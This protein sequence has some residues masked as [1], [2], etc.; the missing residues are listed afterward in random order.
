MLGTMYEYQENCDMWQPPDPRGAGNRN[1]YCIS[2]LC[3]FVTLYWLSHYQRDSVKLV[4]TW[5]TGHHIYLCRN[6]SV[7]C[8]YQAVHSRLVGDYKH[9]LRTCFFASICC[10]INK[11]LKNTAHLL[12]FTERI[13]SNNRLD[14]CF[15]SMCYI[16][17]SILM[18]GGLTLCDR[19]F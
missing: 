4:E 6:A 8:S 15:H 18:F 1:I 19:P 5:V 11:R 7:L 13:S 14:I 16:A 12:V 3:I 10:G 17:T 2:S 9:D